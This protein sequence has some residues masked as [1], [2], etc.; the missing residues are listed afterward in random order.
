MVHALQEAHR[1]ARPGSLV[2]DL[3]PA[4]I[5]RRIAIRRGARLTPGAV[6]QESFNLDRAANAAVAAAI[7]SGLFHQLSSRPFPF[8]RL[9]SSV[10]DFEAWLRD[11]I[12]EDGLPSRARLHEQV[13][14]AYGQ[15]SG[16]R[17]IIVQA[18]VQLRLLR[19]LRAVA[20]APR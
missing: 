2:I 7:R 16:K 15:V 12:D 4:I 14:R 1:V 17:S 13:R 18:P 11:F 19:T 10:D 3:R 9:L 8:N 20:S 5:H 6:M